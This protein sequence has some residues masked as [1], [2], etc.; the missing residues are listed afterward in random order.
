MLVALYLA[1][2]KIKNKILQKKYLLLLVRTLYSY[3][4]HLL[5]STILAHVTP[6]DKTE[7]VAEKQKKNTVGTDAVLVSM[8][9]PYSTI[10]PHVPPL[11][12]TE[13]VAE[14]QTETRTPAPIGADT[15]LVSPSP[16]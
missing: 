13:I 4:H 11:D 15:I 1:G 12:K 3:L 10:L 2:K 6:P 7:I 14:K 5:Y 9:P 16:P 8:S